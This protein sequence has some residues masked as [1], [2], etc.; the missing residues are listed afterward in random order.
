MEEDIDV[1]VSQVPKGRGVSWDQLANRIIT[2]SCGAIRANTNAAFA[3]TK[4]QSVTAC[5]IMKVACAAGDIFVAGENFVIEQ[6]L[7]DARLIRVGGDVII[8]RNP[9]CHR[10]VCTQK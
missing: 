3:N 2:R 8:C 6:K 5:M 10:K 9:L 1:L 7:S 4:R